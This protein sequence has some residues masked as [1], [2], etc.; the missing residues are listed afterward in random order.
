MSA[1]VPNKARGD[2]LPRQQHP[3]PSGSQTWS[4]TSTER[5]FDGDTEEFISSGI[6]FLISR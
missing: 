4:Q 6:G 2:E 1:E 5:N 3:H